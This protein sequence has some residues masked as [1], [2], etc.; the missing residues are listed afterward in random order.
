MSEKIGIIGA[1]NLGMA[2]VKALKKRNLLCWVV[3]SSSEKREILKEILPD[4]IPIHEAIYEI[5]KVPDMIGICVNDSSIRI[6]VDDLRIALGPKLGGKAIF[7]TSAA[8]R[9]DVLDKLKAKGCHTAV[10]HPYQ[11]F[12]NASEDV[13]EGI[14]WSFRTDSKMTVFIDFIKTINGNPVLLTK[15]VDMMMYHCSGVAVSNYLAMVLEFASQVAE[16]AGIN[17]AEY[18]PH[19]VKTTVDNFFSKQPGELTIT[20][21]IMRGDIDTVKKH[22]EALQRYPE[23]QSLYCNL[24][25]ST[26]DMA[27]GRDLLAHEKYLEIIKIL[28]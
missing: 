10:L 17:S 27:R 7:H 6:V 1:G 11:T 4:K 14:N 19:I 20:G 18:F 21:P 5:Q 13:F 25:V 15:N 8:I 28:E 23:L 24:G 3:E 16:K 26:A 12:Y 9:M 2:L 22:M